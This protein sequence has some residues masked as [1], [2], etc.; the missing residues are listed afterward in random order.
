MAFID[1]KDPVVLNIKITSKGRETL[2]K[3]HLHFKYFAIGDSEIDYEFLRNNQGLDNIDDFNPFDSKILRPADKNPQIISFITRNALTENDLLDEFSSNNQY[4]PINNVPSI[5]WEVE[6][7]TPCIGFF[8][9]EGNTFSFKNTEEFVKQPDLMINYATIS[10][11]DNDGIY[12]VIVERAPTYGANVTSPVEGDYLLVRWKDENADFDTTGYTVNREKATPVLIYKIVSFSGDINTDGEVILRVDRKL[13][14]FSSNTTYAGAMILYSDTAV[15][16][17]QQFSTDYASEVLLTF[18]QNCQCDTLDFPFWKMSI[19]YTENI[20]GTTSENK[21]LLQHKSAAF[22]GFVNYIQN[23][24]KVYNKLGVIH[25]TNVSP[26]NTYA[27]Q[28]LKR[29]AMIHIPT[30]M[31]HKSSGDTIGATFKATGDLKTITSDTMLTPSL[32][33]SYYDLADELGNVVGKVFVELKI[34]VIEDPEL[35]FAMSYKSNRSWT[36]PNFNVG[37]NDSITDCPVCTGDIA[38]TYTKQ[39]ATSI[40]GT[41]GNITI[42]NVSGLIFDDPQKVYVKIE[43]T[44][45]SG[46][47][48][49]SEILGSFGKVFGGLPAGTYMVTVTDLGAAYDSSCEAEITGIVIGQPEI[50][51]EREDDGR[52]HDARTPSGIGEN[53]LL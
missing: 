44:S 36:L 21:Q 25:Y 17:E 14:E 39:D 3:G 16:I 11:N 2:S 28:F 1:K 33:T 4:N 22:A 51:R 12:E 10:N 29:T 8:C 38:F 52:G 5:A 6:N 43:R 35:L 24:R 27:E 45:G 37:A 7:T 19:I 13:P 48:Y 46:G 34:F 41:N 23:H 50:I 31:W 53:N 18:L 40:G 32:N 47:I 42:T 20:A 15:N 49:H 26:A 30:I 9:K